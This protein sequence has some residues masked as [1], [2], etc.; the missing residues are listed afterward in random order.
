MSR[1]GL[2]VNRVHRDRGLDGHR[3]E[4]VQ[5]LLS[6][7]WATV[8]RR[9]WRATWRTS[10]CSSGATANQRWPI[11]SKSWRNPTLYSCLI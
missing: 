4:Q 7:S 3:P 6:A 9:A 5:A 1:G 2:I 8:W 11:M 10:T